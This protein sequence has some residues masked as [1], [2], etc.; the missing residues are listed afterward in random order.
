MITLDIYLFNYDSKACN[1]TYHIILH[2]K[3]PD[4]FHWK[5]ICD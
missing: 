2:E 5:M 3:Q 4:N 1:H